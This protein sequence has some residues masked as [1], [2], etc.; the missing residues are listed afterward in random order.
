[1]T[2]VGMIGAGRWGTNWIR[3]LAALPG[4]QLRWVC[5]VSP[6]SLDRVRQQFPHV[7]T[8]TRLEDLF[9]DPTLDGVVIA[10]IAPTHFEVARRALVAG[11]HVMVEKP[12]T[13]TTRDAIELTELARRLHRVLMVGHLLEYHPIIRHIRAMIDGGELGEVY[14][15]YQQ[16]LNLGTI[17]ADENAWWS[18]APHDISVANRLL[19][20]APISVQCRGQ[21][22][23]NGHVADVVFAALEYPGGRLA[24]VHVSWLDPQKSRKLVV[25]GSRKMAIFD[26]TAAQK[27]VV[28]DKGY[29]KNGELITLRQG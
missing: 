26:D 5:D 4:T 15:L 8:T 19:G 14:Y 3:T 21:N 22:I 17:R 18:L 16:R 7:Q 25:I 24:H 23:V 29:Q 13:L 20:A 12:M 2:T 6:A 28:L 27:L 1:M 11:K 10:T 9:A